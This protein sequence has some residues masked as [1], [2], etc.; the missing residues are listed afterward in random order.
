MCKDY[1]LAHG[2]FLVTKE[3]P[4]K[5]LDQVSPVTCPSSFLSIASHSPDSKFY[6]KP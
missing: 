4:N 6:S 2:L 1:Y 5:D 3:A